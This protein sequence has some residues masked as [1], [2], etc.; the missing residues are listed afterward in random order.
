M[1]SGGRANM[2]IL[3]EGVNAEISLQAWRTV[4]ILAENRMIV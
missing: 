1:M 4:L 2:G 3:I